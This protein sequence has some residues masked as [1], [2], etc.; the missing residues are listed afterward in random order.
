M[1]GNTRHLKVISV[2]LLACLHDLQRSSSLMG[3]RLVVLESAPASSLSGDGTHRKVRLLFRVMIRFPSF[4]AVSFGMVA[5]LLFDGSK[6]GSLLA[7]FVMI[8]SSFA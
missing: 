6:D 5:G 8:A 3:G 1:T 7:D 4:L 2:A